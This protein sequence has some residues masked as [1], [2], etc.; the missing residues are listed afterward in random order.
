MLPWLAG[1]NLYAM[2]ALVAVGG[3]IVTGIYTSGQRAER[4]KQ[5]AEMAKI[6]APIIEQR[7]K[8]EAELAA[9]ALGAEMAAKAFASAPRQSLILNEE[10][11]KALGSVGK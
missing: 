5:A 8:D 6:N 2:L 4:N 7:A 11:A 1:K 3:M 9:E 10:T